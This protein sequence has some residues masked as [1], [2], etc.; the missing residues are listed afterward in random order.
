MLGN[1][2]LILETYGYLLKVDDDDNREQAMDSLILACSVLDSKGKNFV[3]VDMSDI[4]RCFWKITEIEPVDTYLMQ[5]G[6][7]ISKALFL[8]D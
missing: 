2:S 7:R 5:F 6:V 1:C 8:K 4:I 3:I